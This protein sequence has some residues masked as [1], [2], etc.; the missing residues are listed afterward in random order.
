MSAKGRLYGWGEAAG[1]G[2]AAEQPVRVHA[3]AVLGVLAGAKRQQSHLSPA[4]RDGLREIPGWDTPR[5]QKEQCE[6]LWNQGFTELADYRAACN[7]WPLHKEAG[8][9]Q[10]RL[11][12]V[13]LHSQRITYRDGTPPGQGIRAEYGASSLAAGPEARQAPTAHA[14]YG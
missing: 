8:S 4:Y 3:G 12:G 10:E 14:G 9:E 1:G 7:D 5:R 6:E 13:W 2:P 11:L